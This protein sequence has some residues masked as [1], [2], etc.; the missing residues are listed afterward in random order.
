MFTLIGRL[1]IKVAQIALPLGFD[2]QYSFDNYFS[3]QS[4]FVTGSLCSL[5]GG[6]GDSMVGLWGGVDSG[7][8][9][10]INA[11]AYFARQQAISFQLYDGADLVK[12]DPS[13]IENLANCR[14]LVVD[15]LDAFCGHRQWEERFYQIINLC[16]DGELNLIFTT[17][18]N[19]L[20]LDC[21]LA[22][23]KSR[24]AWALLLQ[25]PTTEET[26]LGDIIQFR[27]S[28]LGIELS[29]EVIGYLLTHY[30]RRLSEQIKILGILDTASLR[31]QKKISVPMIKHTLAD[32]SDYLP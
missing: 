12:C 23:F 24:L 32:S 25:L 15:N 19:P 27:A 5:I 10:L 14:V 7:K 6:D 2:R 18:S 30:S 22:D 26:G 20:H 29:K 3:E 4:D 16:K 31:M 11:S 1:L 8:T 28:L 17:S 9:H 13:M 21:Q